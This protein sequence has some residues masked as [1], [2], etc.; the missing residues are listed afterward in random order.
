[1]AKAIIELGYRSYVVDVD[2]AVAFAELVSGAE[3]YE[4]KW[5]PKTDDAASFNTYHVYPVTQDHAFN[6]KL[7]T[8]E[9]YRLYKLAGKPEDN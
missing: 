1:M 5:H 4:S 2:K 8:D 9:S 3:I 6:I 7:L